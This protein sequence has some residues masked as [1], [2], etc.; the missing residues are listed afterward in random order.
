MVIIEESE[1]LLA[2]PSDKTDDVLKVLTA[3]HF[4]GHIR[5]SVCV[6]NEKAKKIR[7]LG[8]LDVPIPEDFEK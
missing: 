7:T 5:V 1:T 3:K 4:R 2:I 6:V 8:S